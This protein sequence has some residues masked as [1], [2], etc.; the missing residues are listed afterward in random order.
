MNPP[1]PPAGERSSLIDDYIAG[2]EVGLTRP[3]N[4]ESDRPRVMRDLYRVFHDREMTLAEVTWH[5]HRLHEWRRWSAVDMIDSIDVA[6]LSHAD[7]VYLWNAG[8]A[9]LTTKPGADRLSSLSD[10]ECRLWQERDPA[11]AAVMQACGTW[12]RYWNEEEAYHETSFNRLAALVGMPPVDDATFIE[13]RKI[14]PDDDMLRTLTLLA[15]S[16]IVAATNYAGCARGASHPALKALFQQ[17]S[18]DEIQ[19]MQ[20]FASFARALIDSGQYHAK[21]ALAVAFLF[22]REGGELYGSRRESVEDRGTHVNWWDTL[23]DG[24]AVDRPQTIEKQRG[25]IFT[26]VRQLTDIE[27]TSVDELE[28]AWMDR[29]GC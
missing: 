27:V 29:V 7:R 20:Y 23:D 3:S 4:N 8:R 28:D 16:E 13:F 21:D 1:S 17:V 9:E 24:G 26:L 10:K 6:R 25:M 22:V 12:S 19:H 15:V 14:F 5:Q 11:L 2:R 18:A